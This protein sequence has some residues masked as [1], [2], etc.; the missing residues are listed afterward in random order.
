MR[1]SR[2]TRVFTA[3]LVLIC[4]S[5]SAAPVPGPTE[6]QSNSPAPSETG[7]NARPVPGQASQ[8][9][10]R[11]FTD[12]G[13]QVDSLVDRIR[14]KID[15]SWYKAGE[16]FRL[17][18]ASI[19]DTAEVQKRDIAARAAIKKDELIEEGRQAVKKSADGAIDDLGRRGEELKQDLGR[20]GETITTEASQEIKEKTDRLIP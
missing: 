7:D 10:S 5:L 4:L 20:I 19:N 8:P 15:Y 12:S 16:Y 13:S 2:K 9:K 17:A 14:F 1:S 6:K 3:A 18:I 11:Y